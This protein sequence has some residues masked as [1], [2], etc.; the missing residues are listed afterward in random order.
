MFK[1]VAK[2]PDEVTALRL[3]PVSSGI[4]VGNTIPDFPR[5][6]WHAVLRAF[7][8]LEPEDNGFVRHAR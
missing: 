4:F 1:E 6:T 5:L 8:A 2:L 7:D 3:L